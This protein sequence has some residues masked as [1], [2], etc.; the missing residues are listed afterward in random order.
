M[1]SGIWILGEQ[2]AGRVQRVSF[3]LLARGRQ[4][5]DKRGAELTALVFGHRID[6]GDLKELIERGAD[7]VV[8]MEAPQ[9]EHFL[10]EPYAAC[11]LKLIAERR[12]EIVIAGATSTGRT[13]MPY[14]A[15]KANAGLTA[16]CTSLDI[17][18]ATGELLQTR[19]AIGGNIMATIRTPRHRPQMAT[20]RPRSAKPA[21]R[22]AG[23]KGK[24]ERLP[25]PAELLK[26]RVRRVGFVAEKGEHGIQDADIV[27]AV[28]RGIKKADN[29][30]LVRKLADALGAALGASRD[31]VDRGWLSYP[32][33]IGLSGKTVT[34]RLYIGVGVSGSIQHL[35]GMQTAE[36]IVAINSDPDAQIF[37]VA[38]FGIVGDL[39]EVVP[40]LTEKLSEAR[41]SGAR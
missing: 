3:E 1:Y 31:V 6:A 26:S 19:P 33:Q 41:Q 17:D 14:V 29:V 2:S 34:P 15:V 13:L 36:T 39:F 35:A 4:L 11:M 25:A 5:A 21:P 37:R 40:V 12:P 28:G 9:L 18:A 10:V 7:C 8:A 32:H 20:V 16:D 23:R 22:K 27:V 30:P 38:D 24:I